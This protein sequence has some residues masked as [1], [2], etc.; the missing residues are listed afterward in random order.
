MVIGVG[1]NRLTDGRRV[2]DVDFEAV[3]QK[4]SFNTPVPGGV[5]PMTVTMLLVNM[6]Q[7]AI[8]TRAMAVAA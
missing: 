4:A 1:I 3:R 6:I 5:G 8:R 2:S 7:A